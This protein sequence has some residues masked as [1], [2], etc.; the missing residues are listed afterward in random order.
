ML[1]IEQKFA[2]AD[3]AA[4]EQGLAALAARPAGEV[5]EVDHYF[6]APDRDFART[7]EAFRLRRIG[8]ENYL[9]YKGPRAAH[10]VKTRTELEVP[11]PGGDEAAAQHEQLLRHLGFRPVA[12]VRKRRR[13]YQLE[14]AGFA[15]TVCLD[16]VDD[17]GRFAEVEV[18]A[19]AERVDPARKALAE[20]VASLGLSEVEQRSYLTMLL[21]AKG[22]ESGSGWGSGTGSGGRVPD[23]HP[24]PVPDS[25][26]P[27]VVTDIP[28]LRQ[29]VRQARA[30]NLRVGL[31]PT[32]GA[33]HAGH[34][35]LI[36]AARR[37]TGFVVVSIFVNPTQFGPTEDLDRYPRPLSQDLQRCGRLGVDLVFHP[38]P[39]TMYPP[40]YRTYVEVTGLQDELEGASR[41]GHFRGVA[42]VV[43]KLFNQVQPDRAYFGQKDAQQARIIQQ[44]V[45]D[46]D[47]P[48]EVVVCPTVREADG[49]A[50]SSR[51][52]Y[53]DATQR[54]AAPVL[55]RALQE[56]QTR[57]EAG[58]RDALVLRQLLAD[59]IAETA[60]ATLD[61]AAV[62]D[63]D[64]LAPLTRLDRPALLALAVKF[65]NTRLIDNLQL[66]V[67]S[68][69]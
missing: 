66:Q 39:A 2:R 43:L 14:R 10:A 53:L 47:V 68:S 18:L 1:E 19:E 29:A 41:P 58:E 3:F 46:L 4:L 20:V 31:V 65:G 42:T 38:E 60:G 5:V 37:E 44:L 16:E 25:A 51:N 49:L 26:S 40:G 28:A 59:R 63:A 55:Y 24:D 64:T 67:A 23:P 21:A 52:Q 50:L 22:K 56:A 32:M 62:V 15:F 57:A 6:N 61:Y 13:S 17:L 35:S 8:S 11:L 48:V 30:R 36:A 54:R 9:T 12:A 34:E 69:K 7:G 33:L 27:R 45:R